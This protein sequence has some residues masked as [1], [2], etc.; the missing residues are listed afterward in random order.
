MHDHDRSTLL[1]ALQAAVQEADAREAEARRL[2]RAAWDA[3]IKDGD[4]GRAVGWSRQRARMR[5]LRD[6][7]TL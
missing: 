6:I 5:R 7:T 4:I 1:D 3:G 2:L